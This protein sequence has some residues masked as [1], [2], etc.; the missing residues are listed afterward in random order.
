MARKLQSRRMWRNT[1]GRPLQTSL[2]QFLR[3]TGGATAIIFTMLF[4]VLV[5]GMGLGAEAGYQYM[6]Q[7]KLQ[8]AADVSAHA[9]GARKRAGDSL[10]QIEA[11]ALHIATQSGFLP[12]MGT[13]IVN[14]PPQS[15]ADVGNHNS[16]EVLL[17]L[18]QPR[19]FSAL[20]SDQPVDMQGRAVARVTETGSAACILALSRTDP[21]AITVTG[22]TTVILD[23]CDIAS[24]SNTQDSLLMSGTSATLNMNCGY[25]VG[26]AVT[27]SGLSIG[28]DQIREF[29]PVIR[30]P[31]AD[32][33]EPE[34]VGACRN[35]NQ[36]SPNSTT[37]LTATENH[38]SGVKSMRFCN[39]LD[40]KGNVTFA[41]GLYIIEGGDFT[42]N[43]GNV[44]S[45]SA[46]S[47][48]GDGVTFFLTKGARLRLA[49][50]STLNFAAPTTGPFAGISFFGGRSESGV[51]NRLN[52]SFGSTLQGAIYMPAS[53]VE[54]TGNSKVNSGCTQVIGHKVTFTGN[55]SLRSNCASSGTRRI[56]TNETVRLV[57]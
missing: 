48:G 17:T 38:P 50:N 44:D 51:V 45:S 28:C 19:F 18:T 11:A 47:L 22:S 54:F 27:T 12:E 40:L 29:A 37:T 33:E 46:A 6:S 5:V 21:G 15:G 16:V 35:R 14:I 36:G 39:G 8:H 34:A 1:V 32:I 56:N 23:G 26:Q 55:S 31:Y 43:S 41:P 10:E 7:R 13:M 30:D 53:E 2:R 20:I 52:G 49:S 3:D 24:N 25:V 57:E 9:A 4:P 42:V